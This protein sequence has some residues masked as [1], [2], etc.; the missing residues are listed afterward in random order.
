[1]TSKEIESSG[2][3]ESTEEKEVAKEPDTKD[4]PLISW[5]SMDFE[6]S[7]RSQTWYIAV[8]GVAIALGALLYWQ[9]SWTGIGLVGA[10]LFLLLFSSRQKPKEVE[11]VIYDSGIVIDEKVHSFDD[12]K[13]F[14]LTFGD[15]PKV[16]LQQ[17]GTFTGQVV[18]P[19]Q[20]VDFEDIRKIIAEKLPEENH[21]E[22]LSDTINRFLGL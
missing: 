7:Q 9:K 22:D 18:M 2:K 14:W 10:F 19:L 16:R 4:K 1:M 13:S 20:N 15:L 11:C 17:K 6:Q 8:V 5:K 3:E 21:G 12:F